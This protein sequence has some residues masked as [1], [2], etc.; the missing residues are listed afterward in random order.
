M[1][2]QRDLSALC[3]SIIRLV[4]VKCR[5]GGSHQNPLL[6]FCRSASLD[7]SISILIRLFR[8]ASSFFCNALAALIFF[9]RSPG[10]PCPVRRCVV[11]DP[12]PSNTRPSPSCS[13][14]EEA[15]P[16]PA[17]ATSE[18]SKAVASV[19]R[20]APSTPPGGA[21]ACGGPPGLTAVRSHH[22]Y[23]QAKMSNQRIDTLSTVILRM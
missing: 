23:M 5:Q 21:W 22:E 7:S 6:R 10:T 11:L 19:A 16:P 8:F 13:S 12:P 18:L 3:L 4:N 15:S 17:P 2:G 9:P 20:L 14:Q 1:S